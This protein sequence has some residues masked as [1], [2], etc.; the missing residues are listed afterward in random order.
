MNKR[1][2]STTIISGL[3]FSFLFFGLN[4]QAQDKKPTK[5]KDKKEKKG[6]PLKTERKVE[7][8]TDEGTWLSL[9]LSP[10]GQ[11]IIFDL[12]GDF[13]T[14]SISGG[15]AKPLMTGLPFD[16]QPKFSP[17]G[18]MLTFVSDRNGS[19]NLWISKADGTEAKQLSK[20]KQAEFVSPI[21]T[22]DGDYVIV[23]KSSPATRGAAELWMFHKL[24]GRGLKISKGRPAAPGAPPRA[25]PSAYGAIPT[26]DGKYIYYARKS[27]RSGARLTI[28]N[29]QIVRRNL[30]TGEEDAITFADGNAFRPLVSPDGNT[31][32]FGTRFEGKTGLRVRDL[33]TGEERWLKYPIQRDDQESRPTRDILPGYVFTKDG[34]DI[35]ISYDGKIKRVSVANGKAT[36]IPFSAKVSLDVGPSLYVKKKVDQGIVKARLVQE[37]EV[38]PNGKTIAFSALTA[39]YTLDLP[40]GTPKRL[41]KVNNPREFQPSWSSTLR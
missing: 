2:I 27:P 18:K 9:D 39:L 32:I 29:C 40:N 25:G 15:T 4:I 8:T 19:N 41:T 34:K 37:P 26:N 31:L 3:L 28:P 7:F 14:L 33:N 20:E 30:A 23:T 13:Y 11:T 12:L 22:P 6:L 10:D 35:I 21:W 1:L 17:D 16:S 24:G 36:E 38:S 5:D